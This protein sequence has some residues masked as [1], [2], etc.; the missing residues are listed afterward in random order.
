M[1]FIYL[2][3]IR[4]YKLLWLISRVF[5]AAELGSINTIIALK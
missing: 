2:K 4:S 1:Y 3:L 5:F